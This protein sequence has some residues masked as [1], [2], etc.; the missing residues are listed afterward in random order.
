MMARWAPWLWQKDWLSGQSLVVLEM[1]LLTAALRDDTAASCVCCCAA[2]A[3]PPRAAF[4]SA[5]YEGK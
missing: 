1:N 5:D 3:P 4:L 2:A